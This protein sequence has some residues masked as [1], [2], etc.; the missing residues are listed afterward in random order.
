MYYVYEWFIVETGEI[1]YVGK[2][3]RNRYRVRKHNKLFNEMIKRFFCYSRVVKVF[4]TE[5]EAFEYEFEYINELRKSGQ[6]VCNIYD[7]GNG[8]TTEWWSDEA[9]EKYSERNVMKSVRQRQRMSENNPM[10][11]KEVMKRS[12]ENKRK[13]VIIG[14]IGYPSIK[15]ASKSLNVSTDTITRWCRKGINPAGIECRYVNKEDDLAYG[16]A[17]YVSR[18]KEPVRPIIVNGVWY[19]TTGEASEALGISYTA[20]RSYLTGKRENEMY[21]CEYGDQQPS[22][23][24]TD[25]SIPEGSTTNR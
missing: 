17:N 6:C 3:N 20:L 21:I 22:R 12:S 15:I 24:N 10:K 5:K 7:G 25:N 16:N 4:D 11:N 19:R 1:I 8:G 9:R 23:E 2:G 13:P 14:E 18:H